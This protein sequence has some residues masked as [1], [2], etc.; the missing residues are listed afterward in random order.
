MLSRLVSIALAAAFKKKIILDFTVVGSKMSERKSLESSSS[1]TQHVEIIL[2][3]GH[4]ATLKD[5]PIKVSLDNYY[6]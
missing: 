3:F 4:K 2:E 6:C 5:V 1:K